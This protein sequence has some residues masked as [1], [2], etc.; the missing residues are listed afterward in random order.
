MKLIRCHIENFG[1]LSQ[2]DW[3]FK[4]GLQSICEENGWGKSTFAAFLKVMFYGFGN[5]KKRSATERERM[6]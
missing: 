3:E 2:I 5:E 4:E 6:K 1:T